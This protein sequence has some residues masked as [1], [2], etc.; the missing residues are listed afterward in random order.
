M[1]LARPTPALAAAAV[2]AGCAPGGAEARLPLRGDVTAGPTCPVESASP[3]PSCDDRPVEGQ[4]AASMTPYTRR[5]DR[6]DTP[7]RLTPISQARARPR[8]TGHRSPGR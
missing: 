8:A 7:G 1:L 6:S 2:L 3:D 5:C 4:G